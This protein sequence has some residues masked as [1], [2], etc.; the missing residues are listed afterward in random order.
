MEMFANET[1][2][3]IQYYD[4]SF[5][6]MEQVIVRSEKYLKTQL[7]SSNMME[8]LINDLLDLAKLESNSFNISSEYFD[9]SALICDAFQMM[10]YKA[11]DSKVK[12]R[13]EIDNKK[14]LDLLENVYGD[15]RRFTQIL[16]NFLSNSLKF[17]NPGG[18]VTV[19]LEILDQ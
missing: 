15:Q 17:T 19:R 9:L 11:D 1:L 4:Q 7:F 2:T 18:S 3:T 8:N 6:S 5:K 12:L 14:N 13:A 16:S 10:G